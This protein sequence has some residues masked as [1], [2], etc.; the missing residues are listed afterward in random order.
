MSIDG[1]CGCGD[2]EASP[3][4]QMLLHDV[5]EWIRAQPGGGIA[6]VDFVEYLKQ[7]Q[8]TSIHLQRDTVRKVI[9]DTLG[10]VAVARGVSNSGL[11]KPAFFEL[12]PKFFSVNKKWVRPKAVWG[13]EAQDDDAASDSF[14]SVASGPEERKDERKRRKREERLERE[15]AAAEK[16]AQEAVRVEDEKRKARK[17]R[18]DAAD[19]PTKLQEARTVEEV[20]REILRKKEKDGKKKEEKKDTLED[21]L[22]LRLAAAGKDPATP[23]S[24]PPKPSS[25]TPMHL[26]YETPVSMRT[27]ASDATTPQLFSVNRGMSFDFGDRFEEGEGRWPSWQRAYGWKLDSWGRADS[28]WGQ[29]WQRPGWR[30]SWGKQMQG[31]WKDENWQEQWQASNQV[32]A[33]PGGYCVCVQYITTLNHAVAAVEQLCHAA[34][35]AIDCEGVGLSATGELTL[36]QIAF[37]F[38]Q[39]LTVCVFDAVALGMGLRVLHRVLEE[40]RPLKL[41]HDIR[42]DAAA[43]HRQFGITLRGVLDSQMAYMMCDATSRP[44][45]A[46]PVCIGLNAF[47]RW[48]EVPGNDRKDLVQQ[49]MSVDSQVWKRRPLTATL[50]RYAV[51]DVALLFVAWPHLRQVLGPAQVEQCIDTSEQRAGYQCGL[52]VPVSPLACY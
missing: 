17:E 40:P 46:P 48:C 28:P 4:A 27:D 52:L 12:F 19:A 31:K 30:D 25:S 7:D 16:L 29:S 13:G 34:V 26:Q 18:K 1:W 6:I 21:Q 22:R 8:L 20:E 32:L 43:L 24:T 51:Q 9:R 23:P 2:V 36:L 44:V 33:L 11:I 3:E 5:A 37:S 14:Y 41:F 38:Q 47:L 35:V 45:G 10:P 50:L 15:K 39:R 49:Q 42:Q